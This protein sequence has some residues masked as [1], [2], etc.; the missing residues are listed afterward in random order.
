[1]VEDVCWNNHDGNVFASVS[2]DK[3]LLIWDIRDKS[4]ANSIEAHVAEI[5]SVDY[6]PFD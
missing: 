1:V 5:M 2:D 4:P 6:S 3:R